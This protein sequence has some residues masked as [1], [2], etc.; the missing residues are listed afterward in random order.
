MMRPITPS[1]MSI[2]L[3]FW[4]AFLIAIAFIIFTASFV[5]I[6]L[7]PPLFIW[8]NLADYVAFTARHDQFFQHLARFTMLAFGPLFVL[9]LNSIHDYA[10]EGDRILTRIGLCFGTAFAILTGINYFV[11]LSAVRL[12]LLKGEFQG[13]EQIIQANPNSA[14]SAVNMLGWTLFLGLASLSISPV[15]KGSRLERAIGIAFLLNGV[16][17]LLGGIGYVLD[18][19]V[20][21]FLTINFGMG[22]A[23]LVAAAL[24]C[25]LFNRMQHARSNNA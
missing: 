3:G 15:F 17:C 16:F 6:A 13:L 4:S 11:Q 25:V 21:V 12:S 2:Q 8:T 9:L 19:T 7:A 10:S 5:A 1:R 20:L 18:L 23:V 14:I 24:M 22:G